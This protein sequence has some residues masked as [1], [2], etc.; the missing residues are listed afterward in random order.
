M[1]DRDVIVTKKRLRSIYLE[2]EDD[3]G[4]TL[5]ICLGGPNNGIHFAGLV[6]CT[7]TTP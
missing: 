3:A 5:D 2:K 4:S 7:S 6:T 1:D